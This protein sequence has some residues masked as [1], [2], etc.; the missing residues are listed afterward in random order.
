[1]RDKN[2]QKFFNAA[3]I[4]SLFSSFMHLKCFFGQFL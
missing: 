1:M 4:S 2:S 3:Q